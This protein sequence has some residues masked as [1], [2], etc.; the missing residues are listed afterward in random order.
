VAENSATWCLFSYNLMLLSSSELSVLEALISSDLCILTC[1]GSFDTLSYT[2]AWWLMMLEIWR[3]RSSISCWRSECKSY[4][5]WC[6]FMVISQI[7]WQLNQAR[8]VFVASITEVV[9]YPRFSWMLAVKSRVCI[10]TSDCSGRSLW[11]LELNFLTK[12]WKIVFLSW[13]PTNAAH[14]STR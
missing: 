11:V 4:S 1:T 13:R 3:K 14:W 2:T 10:C 9:V 6:P 7:C 5:L 8:W 12:C